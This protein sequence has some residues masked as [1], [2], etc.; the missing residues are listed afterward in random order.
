M[1]I[2]RASNDLI[3]LELFKLYP[4]SLIERLTLI[5][6]KSIEDGVLPDKLK[7]STIIPCF[8][9]GNRKNCS[10]YRPIS[11]LSYIDKILEK[12]VYQRLYNYLMKTKFLCVN[13][14]GFREN[15]STERAILSL[16]DRIY[17]YIDAKDYVIFISIDLTKAF[18]VI[19]HDILL[20][21]LEY[22]GIRGS[23]LT[24]FKSYLNKSCLLYT[25]PS[26]RDL[27]TSRMP[28]SA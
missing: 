8:K 11:L 13:Q 5:F 15:H 9:K 7:F 6:N 21:K 23:I 4:K 26:P 25:S 16:M 3:P 1:K 27:S 22:A 19:R 28:S 10:N 14:F 2:K 24:W 12:A 17:K 18:D 20:K